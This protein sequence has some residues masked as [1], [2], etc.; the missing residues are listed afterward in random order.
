M[1][2][3][4]S[5]ANVKTPIDSAFLHVLRSW[6]NNDPMMLSSPTIYDFRLDGWTPATLP[7]ARLAE[8]LARLAALFGN[9]A[10]VYFLK[11]RKGSAIQEIHV[12]ATAA[13]KVQARLKL[14]GTGEESEDAAKS[15]Q[16]I[17]AMLRED[18]TSATLKQK[19]GAVLI[20]FPGCKTT[21]AEEAVVHESGELIGMVIRVGGRDETVPLLLQDTDGTTCHCN[22]SRAI[23]RELAHH[24]FGDLVRVQG[25]GKWRRTPER[26]WVLDDFKIKSWERLEQTSLE[27]AVT[28]VREI[29]GSAWNAFANPHAE[30]KK[31]REA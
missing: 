17:N 22:T 1:V 7:M 6:W 19:A 16:A 12:R 29:E 15:V 27:A 5:H 24:L 9:R 2:W 4:R 8:Y 13:L 23:A 14:V 18:N 3:L 28:A 20:R 26:I 31:L 11:A 25:T 30:L 21:L 10:D